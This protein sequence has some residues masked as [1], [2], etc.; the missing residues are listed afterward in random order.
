M[1]PR[2]PLT[3][4]ILVAMVAAGQAQTRS[5]RPTGSSEKPNFSGD[6]ILNRELSDA[7]RCARQPRGRAA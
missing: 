6:W 7:G 5:D 3:A 2:A 4:V 1:T